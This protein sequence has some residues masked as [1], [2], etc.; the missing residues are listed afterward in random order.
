MSKEQWNTRYLSGEYIYGTD[1]NKFLSSFLQAHEPGMI[2][3]PAEGEGRNAVYAASL[4]WKADA[5]DQSE[6]GREK[7]LQLAA[8]KGVSIDYSVCSL[9]DWEPQEAQ[10]DC[11]VLIFVHLPS[12]LRR[13]VHTKAIRALK[14]GGHIVLEA[15]TKNQMPRTSGGP[16]NLELLFDPDDI[17]NDFDGLEIIEF[18]ETQ[19][20]LDEGPLHQGL[21]DVVRMIAA[22]KR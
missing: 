3:F 13:S 10:Y 6:N 22:K 4:G 1:P 11:V 19:V 18:S 21:A 17:R 9:E 5:F 2:L 12:G 15:F 8:A 7:A 20:I 16:K 14:P